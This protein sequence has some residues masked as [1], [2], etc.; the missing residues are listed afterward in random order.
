[1][2]IRIFKVSTKEMYTFNNKTELYN[3]VKCVIGAP[4]FYNKTIPQI[5]AYLPAEDYC[6]VT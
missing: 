4:I 1:M 3:F 5:I 6:R 2:V